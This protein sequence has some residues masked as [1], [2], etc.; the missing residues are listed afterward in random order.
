MNK[1]WL[2]SVPYTATVIL[3]IFMFAAYLE[4]LLG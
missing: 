1:F 2:E 4:G 3:G